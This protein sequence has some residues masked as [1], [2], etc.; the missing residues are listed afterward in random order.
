VVDGLTRVELQLGAEYQVDQ[1]QRDPSQADP[2]PLVGRLG[3]E[4]FPGVWSGRVLG[5]YWPGSAV[6]QLNAFVFEP[7]APLREIWEP[8]LRL[9]ALSTLVHE[10]GHH[11]D[12]TMRVARG[13]WLAHGHDRVEMYAEDRQQVWLHAAVVP[14]LRAAYPADVA[15]LEAWIGHHGGVRIP[16][17][18]L[19]DDPRA[20]RKDGHFSVNATIWSMQLFMQGLVKLVADGVQL[21]ECRVAFARD[22]HYREMYY[23]ALQGLNRVLAD[24][25]RHVGARTLR[26]DILEH[27]G[28]SE[29][30]LAIARE[31]LGDAPDCGDAW[32]V[33]TDAL[34]SLERW[35]EMRSAADRLVELYADDKWRRFHA[36]D[37]RAR[38]A[39]A[40]GD[41]EAASADLARMEGDYP[42]RSK[43]KSVQRLRTS[44]EQAA[45][46]AAADVNS[47]T[48]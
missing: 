37:Q 39:L 23:E 21:D 33:V 36:L 1:E 30:A 45:R 43:A 8:M 24:E 40:L 18:V 32:E 20:T 17:E 25:P 28:H 47:S 14:Y 48:S 7:D 46:Q 10:V 31:V 19:A 15:R 44:I 4:S 38:A 2:D 22:L 12:H 3:Y 16:L 9:Q 26:A 34:E 29:E 6:I 5:V 13:R 35:G 41:V 42:Q 27:Q 11:F